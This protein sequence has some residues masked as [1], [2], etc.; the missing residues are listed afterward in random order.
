MKKILFILMVL[1][2]INMAQIP[3]P[4]PGTYVNDNAAVLSPAQIEQLNK[5]A[6]ALE[7]V[8]SV[9]IAI[10]IVQQL[11]ENKQID[12]FAR[13]VGRKWHV[14]NAANGMVYVLALKE[15]KQRLEVARELEGT[16]PDIIALHFLDEAKPFMKDKQ[17]FAGIFHI[18]QLVQEKIKPAA[19]EQKQL[20]ASPAKDDELSGGWIMIILIGI[21]TLIF[22]LIW[23]FNRK[24]QDE[25]DN[26]QYEREHERLGSLPRND[27]YNSAINAAALGY[28][29][30]YITRND[31]KNDD[32]PQHSSNDDESASSSSLNNYGNWG[33]GNND[34]NSS[35]SSSSGYDG[36]GA[37]SDF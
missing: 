18:L 35:S 28:A 1:P 3:D 9:Q 37:T 26:L 20:A 15:R 4:K 36:A 2:I 31:Y 6:H 29:A 25:V 12:D 27:H 16:I 10:I 22:F 23:I 17:Y 11:P 14:G 8:T 5:Q 34:D 30:G 21:A 7:M 19:A 24:D 32:S 13:E 33:G